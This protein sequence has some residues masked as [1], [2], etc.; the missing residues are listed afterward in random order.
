MSNRG[1]Y[2][3]M[4]PLWT[5]EGEETFTDL[6]RRS[7][8]GDCVNSVA[9][10][11]NNYLGAVLSYSE[12]V[13]MEEGLAPEAQRMLREIGAAVDKSSKLLQTLMGIARQERPS[14]S[15]TELPPLVER[16][17]ALRKY[18]FGVN[19]IKVETAVINN[20]GTFII[21]EPKMVR[22]LLALLMNAVEHVIGSTPARIDITIEGTD[23]GLE[24]RFHDSGQPVP[25][26]D[27]PFM[28]EPFFTTKHNG[29]IGLGL[30][31]ALE[32]ARHHSGDLTYDPDRGFILSLPRNTGIA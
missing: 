20:P 13:G 21:D 5:V 12:L 24:I 28:F 6:Y 14:A 3:G 27:R 11:L 17:I 26:E 23:N 30:T 9:H 16:V 19:R 18:E 10:D 2:D 31:Q 1:I 32:T 7:Q 22:T 4:E 8:V 25:V 15:M 29:H